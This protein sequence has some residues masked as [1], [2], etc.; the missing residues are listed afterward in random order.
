MQKE[1]KVLQYATEE[2][3]IDPELLRTF[4]Q[5]IPQNVWQSESEQVRKKAVRAL[6]QFA[7]EAH[8]LQM[9]CVKACVQNEGFVRAA[10][11]IFKNDSVVE[12]VLSSMGHRDDDDDD[13]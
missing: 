2:M 6:G 13:D 5:A 4:Q 11:S 9:E 12:A 10:A 8:P 7:G 3:K 1:G